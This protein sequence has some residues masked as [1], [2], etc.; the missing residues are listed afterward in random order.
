MKQQVY[1][2]RH[3]VIVQGSHHFVT[4]IGSQVYT[5]LLTRRAALQESPIVMASPE[6]PKKRKR[7]VKLGG[8]RP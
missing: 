8:K 6:R 5:S 2:S 3:D 7:L 1:L 4:K